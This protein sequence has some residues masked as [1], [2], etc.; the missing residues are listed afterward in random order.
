M[1]NKKFN[2]LLQ[3]NLKNYPKFNNVSKKNSSISNY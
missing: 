1:Q 3:Q 2:K